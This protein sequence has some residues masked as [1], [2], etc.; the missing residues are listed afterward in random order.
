MAST[1][2]VGIWGSCLLAN[3]VVCFTQE[4]DDIVGAFRL[5][6]KTSKSVLAE[7]AEYRLHRIKVIFRLIFGTQQE[8]D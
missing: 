3:S 4:R 6:E 5:P 8:H 2:V 1:A 7:A